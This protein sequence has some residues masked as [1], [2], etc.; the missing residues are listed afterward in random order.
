MAVGKGFR[1]AEECEVDMLERIG[2]D[3]LH[4]CDLVAH[5]VELAQ[6]LVLIEERKRCGGQGRLGNCVFQLLPQ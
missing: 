1:P 5:L 6:A 4:E 3:G 2:V